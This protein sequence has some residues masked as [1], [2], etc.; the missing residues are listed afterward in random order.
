MPLPPPLPEGDSRLSGLDWTLVGGGGVLLATIAFV[1]WLRR[2]SLPKDV[3]VTALA[4]EADGVDGGRDSSDIF[5]WG[6]EPSAATDYEPAP[7]S[8]QGPSLSAG[9][10]MDDEYVKE[11]EMDTETRTIQTGLG[12][13]ETPTVA[14]GAAGGDVARMLSEL[15]G[16]VAQ[17]E[18]RLDEAVDARER[19]ERQV[20][21][22][23]E[24]LRVQRAAIARTQRALRSM[25]RG[26]EEQATEPAIR[27]PS[28]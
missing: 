12:G 25:K 26:D 1:L 13:A 21:A 10:G 17:M 20:A 18:A 16:R 4:Q 5:G 24:E 27:E 14:G 7:P 23:A 9:P 6:E 22:Q 15:E 28:S 8:T 11:N 3:D 19:L 2:R